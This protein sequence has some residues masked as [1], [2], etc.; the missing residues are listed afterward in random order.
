MPLPLDLLL[1]TAGVAIG[2]VLLLVSARSGGRGLVLLVA[3]A[4]SYLI[5]SAPIQPCCDSAWT[6][7]VLLG[8]L[9]FP[10]AFW[11]LAR[12]TLQDDASIPPAAWAGLAVMVAS[13]V[14][15]AGRYLHLPPEW[16][17]TAAGVN[18]AAG[19]AFIGS[20][21]FAGWRT[22]DGD[23]VEPRR[24]LRWV[25][26][27][28][29]GAYGVVVMVAE[30]WFFNER[31]PAWLDLLNAAAITATL[32]AI[33]LYLVQPRAAALETLF[34]PPAPP[35]GPGE[36]LPRESADEPVLLRLRELMET[37]H[38]YREPDLSVGM[39]AAR[40]GVPEYVLRRLIHERLGHRNFAAYVNDYRLREVAA[41]LR[42]PQWARRPILTL[43]LEAGFGS[44]GPF[45]RAFRERHGVTPTAWRTSQPEAFAGGQPQETM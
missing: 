28:Y 1:R 24:R 8:A 20:A 45:N 22:W 14:M 25:L 41:R 4:V 12:V 31:A 30:L 43:A 35:A 37:Q 3:C 7:P 2:A 9:A 44:I 29:V 27:G 6:L 5:C 42:D 13:G 11:R 19:F 21:L 32:L 40:A 23:L 15:A 10:F 36:R 38:L 34:A 17:V 39:L 26:V 18:K 16:C 33:L